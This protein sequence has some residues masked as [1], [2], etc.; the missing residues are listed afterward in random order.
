MPSQSLLLLS[1]AKLRLN[2]AITS[3]RISITS[4]GIIRK[5]IRIKLERRL[6]KTPRYTY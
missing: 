2:I 4:H 3:T 1:L 5:N 6:N